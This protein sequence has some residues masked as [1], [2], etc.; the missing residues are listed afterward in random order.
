M[1]SST[2]TVFLTELAIELV[3]DCYWILTKPLIYSSSV[4]GSFIVPIGFETDLASVPRVP[5]IYELWG[6]RAHREAVLHDFLYCY[7]CQDNVSLST[8]N[9]IFLEAMKSRKVKWW[10]RYPMYYGVC[11]IGWKFFHK[12]SY[13]ERIEKCYIN[14]MLLS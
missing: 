11:L 7:D 1:N 10:I 5:F 13:K 2:E 12:R 6:M 3:G 4:Y 14:N 8:A 9:N